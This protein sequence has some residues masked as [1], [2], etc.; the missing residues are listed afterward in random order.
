V[1][2]FWKAI[3]NV[4]KAPYQKFFKKGNAQNG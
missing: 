3:R 4:Q 2:K 1:D